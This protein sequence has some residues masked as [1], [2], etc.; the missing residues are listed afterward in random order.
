MAETEKFSFT[1]AHELSHAVAAGLLSEK[2][3]RQVYWS[4]FMV[5]TQA[6]QYPD[7]ALAVPELPA[8]G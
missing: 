4:Q 8:G 7:A 3:A 5:L 1:P 6:A 2:E